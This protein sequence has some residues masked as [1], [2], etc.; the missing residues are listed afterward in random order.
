MSLV[1]AWLTAFLMGRSQFIRT[2]QMVGGTPHG[3]TRLIQFESHR[4]HGL[5]QWLLGLWLDLVLLNLYKSRLLV[6]V[7]T[8]LKFGSCQLRRN[9]W[10]Y[11]VI[12]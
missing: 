2:S 3:S 7:I 8:Q 10:K 11:R 4:F 9:A 1:S 5:R 12:T 6:G